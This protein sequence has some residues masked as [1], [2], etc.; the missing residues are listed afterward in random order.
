MVLITGACSGASHDGECPISL[1]LPIEML[2]G[3]H[4]A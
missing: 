3:Q 4:L 1:N 2:D